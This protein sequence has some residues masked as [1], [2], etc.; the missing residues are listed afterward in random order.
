MK[1]ILINNRNFRTNVI[2]G[3][4]AII[5]AGCAS[6]P[7]KDISLIPTKTDQV[8]S[9]EGAFVQKVKWT[10]TKPDCSG[11]C[12]VLEL[13][14]LVFPGNNVLTNLIDNTLAAMTYTEDDANIPYN[15][16]QQYEQYYW[17]TAADRDVTQLNAKTR[18][19]NKF[20]TSL[21]LNAG[22][23]VTGAAHGYTVTKFL[24]WDNQVGKVLSLQDLIQPGSY[25]RYVQNL[26]YAHK[27]WVHNL[28]EARQDIENWN[29]MWPFAPSDNIAI[30][31]QGLLV[32]Y[33]SYE[34]AP[35]SSGQP[36]MI[37]PFNLLH[38]VLKPEYR[39]VE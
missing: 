38:D 14:S 10:H 32:K 17:Q 25:D 11:D 15:S 20:I 27:K 28:P 34:I 22:M 23:Y 21:E 13:D 39:P 4:M 36:E 29:R 12:P 8:T 7:S 37:I 3:S 6:G 24:N 31:D 2:I 18:Y 35:Y 16:V 33:N 30:T 19:R 5:L 1:T 9:T 26:K